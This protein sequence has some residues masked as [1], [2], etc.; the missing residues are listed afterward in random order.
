MTIDL[1][2]GKPSRVLLRFSLPMVFSVLLQQLYVLVDLFVVG[3][4]TQSPE[5]A[6][7]AVA[8]A[9]SVTA[10]YTA[11]AV[12][13]N[14]GCSV[15]IARLF[16]GK[17]YRDLHTAVRTA[18]LGASAI[19]LVLT[20]LGFVFCKPL[21]S[22]INTPASAMET[23]VEYLYIYTGSLL[24]VFLYNI[25]TGICN[26]LGDSS[27]PLYFLAGSSFG[28]VLL[29]LLFVGVF[30]WGVVGAAW[31]TLIAQVVSACGLFVLLLFRLSKLEG[32][33]APW[34]RSPILKELISLSV[35][36][37]FQQSF[38]AVGNFFIQRVIDNLGNEAT[39]AGFSTA[40]KVNGFA[41]SCLVTV[42]SAMAAYTAQNV[43]A[44]QTLRVKQGFTAGVKMLYMLILPIAAAFCLGAPFFIKLFLN[45]DN[46]AII[47]EAV[48][49]GSTFLRIAAPFYLV[50]AVKIA[51]DG[52]LRGYG[53]MK[54]FT[55]STIADLFFR[56]AL[57][58]LLTALGMGIYAIPT[59]WIVGWT[60]ASAMAAVFYKMRVWEKKRI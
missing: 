17:Q 54:Y 12:G 29:D 59:A 44:K 45:T 53:A 41:T 35:P 40:L 15:L 7:S 30:R 4:Y 49:A 43:G 36:T 21:L 14:A 11:V 19:S 23:A 47:E 22:L 52:I 31:A 3:N 27:T 28:N 51:C 55:A 13:F 42:C 39:I 56:V 32:R 58:Y 20:I 33:D 25:S 46:T 60:I 10:I 48:S 6:V 1:T 16:G 37:V 9:S 57:C 24:F 2:A 8:A 38:I 34:V 50:I 26:A 5:V 18:W